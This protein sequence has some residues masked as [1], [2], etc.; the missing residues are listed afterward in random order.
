MKADEIPMEKT[1][2]REKFDIKSAPP[3]WIMKAEIKRRLSLK[4]SRERTKKKTTQ[5][6][7]SKSR[8]RLTT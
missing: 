4:E 3:L 1:M 5:E 2:K 8:E 6:S 7:I